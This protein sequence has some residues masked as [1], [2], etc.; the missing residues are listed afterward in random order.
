MKCERVEELLIDYLHG[1]IE[2]EEKGLVESH[3]QGCNDCSE[4]FAEFK[5]I[6]SAFQSEILPE[7]SQDVLQSL[8][9]KARRDLQNEKV[10]FW[11]KW[12]Y[13]PILIPTLTTA[14]ALMVWINVG[15]NNTSEF[16]DEPEYYSREVMAEKIPQKEIAGKAIVKGQG[17]FRA[18]DDLAGHKQ[19]SFAAS[20]GTIGERR[21]DMAAAPPSLR[22]E[23]SE[24]QLRPHD[25]RF[26][27]IEKR[28]ETLLS[29]S[30]PQR[31]SNEETPSEYENNK[32]KSLK[33]A[34]NM[35]ARQEVLEKLKNEKSVDSVNKT[36][37][38]QG[39]D[40]LV[41]IESKPDAGAVVENKDDD[42]FR[43]SLGSSKVMAK[44]VYKPSDDSNEAD[45]DVA[46]DN[47]DLEVTGVND[48]I[49][50][51]VS[52]QVRSAE[53]TETVKKE[54]LKQARV[55]VIDSPK[56]L[57]DKSSLRQ[58]GIALSQQ[59]AGDCKSAIATNEYNLKNSPDAPDSV[60]E[61]TYLS[62]AQCYEQQNMF[63]KAIENYNYLQQVAPSQKPFAAQKIEEL[64][65]K[66]QQLNVPAA[67]SEPST[68]SETGVEVTK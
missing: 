9:I 57:S 26:K 30:V 59:K 68:T 46:E 64:N 18:A 40:R 6:Q 51:K 67:I 52:E 48:A 24:G 53:K 47:K 42:G 31:T 7:P 61:Q 21:R 11:R 13:S 50:R 35:A 27:E 49:E 15:G 19:N 43:F 55:G 16:G 36:P 23:F 28:G 45:L 22:D 10:S 34:S 25:E 39:Y 65:F 66:V 3:L 56:E 37:A 62:L 33:P 38:A 60:K 20:E 8:T 32:A 41:S 2:S 44:K 5:E 17:N 14:I 63:V 4:K 12:F 1:E 58:L 29:E 54:K